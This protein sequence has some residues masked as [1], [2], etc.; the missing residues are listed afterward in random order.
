MDDLTNVE[1]TP[2]QMEAI[3]FMVEEEAKE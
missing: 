2:A 1:F 3:M